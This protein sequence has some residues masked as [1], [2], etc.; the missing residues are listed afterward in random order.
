VAASLV[1]GGLLHVATDHADYAQEVVEAAAAVPALVTV[2]DAAG[3]PGRSAGERATVFERRWREMGR[4][5]HALTLRRAP[6][7][8]TP[9]GA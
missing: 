9:S 3:F 2:P 1:D 5:I 4:D 7:D 8:A 6:R